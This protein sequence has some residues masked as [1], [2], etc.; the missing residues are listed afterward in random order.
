[1][2]FIADGLL[3]FRR[4]A[5]K[6]HPD[7]P[8][9]WRNES[10]ATMPETPYVLI[11]EIDRSVNQSEDLRAVGADGEMEFY[12]HVR[13]MVRLMFVSDSPQKSMD[14]AHK[15]WRHMRLQSF[16]MAADY[17]GIAVGPPTGIQTV[18]LPDYSSGE[19]SIKAVAMTTVRVAYVEVYRDNLGVIKHAEAHGK[20]GELDTTLIINDKE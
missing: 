17:D 16:M 1:M 4:H 8:W 9:L 18:Q 5:K 6:S 19:M 3:T 7:I 20:F 12:E 11:E 14:M 2:S 10:R 13:S 15:A